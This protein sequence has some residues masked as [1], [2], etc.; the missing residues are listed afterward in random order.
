LGQE[1]IYV[2]VFN[3]LRE[4]GLDAVVKLLRL[5]TKRHDATLLIFDGLL[6]ARERASTELDVKTFVAE[7]QG[8]AAFVG[9]TV[10]FLTSTRLDDSSPEHTMVE[11]V[12]DLSEELF[13]VR[14]IRQLQLRKSRGSASLGGLHQYEIDDSGITVYPRI[15]SMAWPIDAAVSP[16]RRISTGLQAMDTLTG[17]GLPKG[18]VTLL[19]GPAGSGKTTL[20]LHFLSAGSVEERAL[21]FGFFETPTL[22][23]RQAEAFDIL[24]PEQSSGALEIIWNPLAENLLDKLG[25]QLLEHVVARNVRRLFIDGFGG[26][27]RATVHR[28]RLVE[29]F[30]ILTGQLR[31]L[32]VTTVFTWELRE[33]VETG[34]SLPSVEL[35][36]M[37]DNL[38]LL[39]QV[40]ENH[41]FRRTIAIQKMRNST[42]DTITHSLEFTN[43]G[44]S[45]GPRLASADRPHSTASK[46]SES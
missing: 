7:V 41:D 18:S 36:G 19:A 44:L 24:L 1:I 43:R 10:L 46:S 16:M 14:T 22:L 45:V 12:L 37:I 26:F 6:N 27:E 23:R 32:G 20:G 5:E 21:H 31:R 8:Q 38:V 17:G 3:A 39:R 15:E 40:E 4:E 13:G 11:G 42:F 2:S 9:C 35:S 29:F 30:S 28:H 25:H 33:T 34:T